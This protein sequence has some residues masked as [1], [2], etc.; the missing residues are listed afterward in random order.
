M[1]KV[2]VKSFEGRK[3]FYGPF[4]CHP[5]RISLFFPV[6]PGYCLIRKHCFVCCQSDS[7]NKG[8]TFVMD[9]LPLCWQ[10]HN[11]LLHRPKLTGSFSFQFEK[12]KQHDIRSFFSPSS[13]KEKKRKRTGV[14]EASPSVSSQTNA[15]FE[16]NEERIE[17]PC[18]R[19]P[20]TPDQ[21]FSPQL[22]RL[23]T[24]QASPSSR[25]RSGGKR[26]STAG[27]SGSFSP[28]PMAL[29]TAAQKLSEPDPPSTWH[30]GACTY[31]NSSLLPYCEM[32]E[33]PRSSSAAGPGK[34]RE[35]V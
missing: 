26:R 17:S 18:S 15:H 19:V 30:C 20:D 11:C 2:T 21:D 12:E 35:Q 32:C 31:S 29:L 5:K 27:R 3:D 8:E 10:V 24:P 14:E 4:C 1:N 25:S 22:K 28:S 13:S 23:R 34:I 9:V 16:N 6:L 33:F 7:D